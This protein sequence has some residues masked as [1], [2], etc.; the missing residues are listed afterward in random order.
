MIQDVLGIMPRPLH[1]LRVSPRHWLAAL[2]M[3]LVLHGASAQPTTAPV[4]QP[5]PPNATLDQCVE[6]ALRNQPLVRQSQLDERIADRNVRIGLS[7]W[8]PQINGT[9]AYTR[10]IQLQASVLPNFAD[11][12]AGQQ[13]IR[14][15]L[16]NVSTLGLQATQLL[17]SNDVLRAARS[18]RATRLNYAQT[19][20]LNKIDVVTNVSKAFYDILLTEEQ[21]RIL[22]EV[23]Q[24]QERQVRDAKAQYEVGIAD[25]TDFLRADISLKNAVAQRRSLAAAL[26]GKYATLKQLMGIESGNK[27]ALRYDTLE[28][29]RQTLLDTTVQLAYEKR[30]EIQQLQTQKQLQRYNIDYYRYGFLPSLSSFYNY[31]R[32]YQNNEF[33]ELYKRAFP[34]QQAGLQLALPIFTGT[35][36][37]QNLKIAELQD[38]QLDLTIFDTKNQ[39]NSEFEQAM[40]AYKGSLNELY[41][42]EQN[43]AEAKEVYRILNLQYREGLRTFLDVIIAETDLRT[44]QLNYY[45]ALFN[46]LSTKLDVQ[47]ALGNITFNQNQ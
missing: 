40:G 4:G 19:T 12:S 46:V 47:R 30:V 14:I 6:F 35:R 5:L 32:V 42:I 25:K 17:Y 28:M 20:A 7:Y 31:N 11:P 43:V 27:L 3:L 34:N 18:V 8:L 10:N 2:A 39:I 45:N 23:L 24:R 26:P 15:G 36:R 21:L 13:I 33:S 38:E 9:G 16:K 1:R 44:A 22:L 37:L 29:V 41:T